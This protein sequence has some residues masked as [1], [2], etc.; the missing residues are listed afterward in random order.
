ME[1]LLCDDSLSCILSTVSC[2]YY[3]SILKKT[4][5]GRNSLAVQWLGPGTFTA[6]GPGSIPGQGTK[7]CK[8]RGTAQKEKKKKKKD[9]G[10]YLLYAVYATQKTII[11]QIL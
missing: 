1:C 4:W 9:M 11:T 3:I 2:M 8:P 5:V 10:H 7:L 6:G